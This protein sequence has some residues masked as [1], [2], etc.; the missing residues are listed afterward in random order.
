MIKHWQVKTGSIDITGVQAETPIEAATRV[1]DMLREDAKIEAENRLYNIGMIVEC[2][3][4]QE[5]R[6]DPEN[7]TFYILSSNVLANAGLYTLAKEMD[8]YVK[9]YMNEEKRL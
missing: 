2:I 8:D 4:L 7:N 5:A 3:D 1:F 6:K 9:E